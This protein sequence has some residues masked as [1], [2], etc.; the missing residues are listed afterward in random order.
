MSPLR[1]GI[2]CTF[3]LSLAATALLAQGKPTT[4]GT[5]PIAATVP[6]VVDRNGKV[7]G[8]LSAHTGVVFTL[9]DGRKTL[10]GWG[11]SGLGNTGGALSPN[12]RIMFRTT[13]CSGPAYVDR[14]SFAGD[15]MAMILRFPA[16]PTGPYVEA[17]GEDPPMFAETAI[18]YVSET[19]ARL[20]LRQNNFLSY[21]SN[22]PTY[23]IVGPC[24]P[25][26][27]PQP[28]E[29]FIPAYR[30]DS[31]GIDLLTYFEYPFHVK[32]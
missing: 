31:T 27:A 11:R 22:T 17:E 4:P 21:Y 24:V 23:P 7:V 20:L 13:D 10:L 28:W 3:L 18:L 16:P 6:E 29:L 2:V 30:F 9:P 32:E 15:P 14:G 26:P 1:R 25:A 12:A 19:G 5:S 8:P